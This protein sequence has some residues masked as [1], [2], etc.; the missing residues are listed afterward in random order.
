MRRRS[1][2]IG[3]GAFLTAP[4]VAKVE[5]SIAQKAMVEPLITEA[6]ASRVL[7][8]VPNHRGFVITFDEEEDLPE[9]TYREM[10]D[11]FHGQWFQPGA[12][13]SEE[14]AEELGD[15]Y[16]I[17]PAQ[18][19]DIAPPGTYEAEWR[20]RNNPTLNAFNF[21]DDLD[22]GP[23]DEEGDDLRGDL[24]FIEG[25]HP[26]S[27]YIAVEAPNEL[28]LHLLQARLLD[29]GENVYIRIERAA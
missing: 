21:L 29:L 20:E 9:L 1:F 26:G 24:L 18:L 23:E 4:Y 14:E 13:L 19:D 25:E 11:E 6:S 22:L 8:A 28:T 5:A 7:R 12:P 10:L 2:L 17:T 27:T 16:E 3:L 15:I